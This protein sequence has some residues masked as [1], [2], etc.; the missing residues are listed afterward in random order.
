MCDQENAVLVHC[1]ITSYD[2]AVIEN[3][4]NTQ[5]E[6]RSPK[7]N[8]VFI[9]FGKST[10]VKQKGTGLSSAISSLLCILLAVFWIHVQYIK[11]AD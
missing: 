8:T 6:W 2:I 4:Y 9:Y 10:L 11:A 5:L 1:K 3:V 7:K